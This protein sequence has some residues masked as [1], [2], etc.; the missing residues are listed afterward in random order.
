MN[1]AKLKEILSRYPDD[2]EIRDEQ[3]ENF[4]H[5]VNID[6]VLVISTQRPIGYC[7]RSGEYVYPSRIG[8]YTAFSPSLDEDLYT[9]E[10]TPLDKKQKDGIQL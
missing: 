9:S 2:M 4:I 8:G 5:S 3:N 10:W 7:N 1:I 6:D